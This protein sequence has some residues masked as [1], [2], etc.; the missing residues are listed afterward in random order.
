MSRTRTWEISDELWS[1]VEPCLPTQAQ[2]RIAGKKYKRKTGGERKARYTPRLYFSAIVYILRTGIQWNALPREKFQGVSSSAVHNRFRKWSD[3]GFFLKLWRMG[4][5]EY[6]EFEGIA[7]EWQSADG[8][9]QEAPLAREAVGP[10]PT[11]REKKG[12][13]GTRSST[14]MASRCPSSQPRRTCMTASNWTNCSRENRSGRGAKTPW[15]K[16]FAWMRG[17]AGKR[18]RRSGTA[19]CPTSGREAKRPTN[20]NGI[21]DRRREDVLWRPSIR[22]STGSGKSSRGTKSP[23]VPSMRCFI[24]RC[25]WSF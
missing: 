22:G 10:N 6:D 19:M 20:S 12:A 9:L 4:L 5:A 8:S 14:G 13:K 17:I 21:R 2:L 7:W 15:R 24:W 23:F 18:R 11:D 3:A 16:I 25:A 1:R